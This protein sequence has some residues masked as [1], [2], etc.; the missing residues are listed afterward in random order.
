MIQ[1]APQKLQ[2]GQILT[3]HEAHC[4]V[5]VLCRVV[6]CLQIALSCQQTEAQQNVRLALHFWRPT[7]MSYRSSCV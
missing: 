2:L 7:G 3:V 4:A 5:A 1:H 6:Q